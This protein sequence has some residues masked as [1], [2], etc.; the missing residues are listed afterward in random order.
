MLGAI[1]P[2]GRLDTERTVCAK[3]PCLA[4]DNST[5]VPAGAGDVRDMLATTGSPGNADMGVTVIDNTL[6]P[7]PPPPPPPPL[8]GVGGSVSVCSHVSR[9]GLVAGKPVPPKRTMV[10]RAASVR[11]NSRQLTMLA[12]IR[13]ASSRFVA[14]QQ[15]G[16][17][18]PA[19]FVFLG[20]LLP[21][22]V[23]HG[24]MHG[25]VH[26]AGTML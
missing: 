4:H 13:R 19:R 20:K 7:P 25:G 23:A 12:A 8:G 5:W 2:A 10:R 22:V 17:R 1:S 6:T 16:R 26:V 18:S 14:R 24:T 15:L 3:S 11:R 9:S 21:V